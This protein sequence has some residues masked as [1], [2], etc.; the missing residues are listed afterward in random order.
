MNEAEKKKMIEY[1]SSFITK[2]RN[3]LLKRNLQNR[4]NHLSIILED[5]FHSQNASA[6]LRTADC[7]GIQNIHIIENNNTYNTNPNI[8]LG[9]SKWITHNFYN[10]YENNTITCIKELKS[11]GY[12]IIATSPHAKQSVHE[13]KFTKDKIALLFGSELDG[14]SDL[15]I[16]HS[17]EIVNIPMFGFTESY[18]ISVAAALCINS[19]FIKI[20]KSRIDWRLTDKEQDEVML[21]WLRNSLKDYNMI[22]KR[23]IDNNYKI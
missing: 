19:I 22:E 13:I 12:R 21:N 5:I 6:V 17:D 9:S 2:E 14:L 16:E 10:K 7:F 11:K 20:R 8:S 23:F 3:L 15:A 4:T 18:N 1:L